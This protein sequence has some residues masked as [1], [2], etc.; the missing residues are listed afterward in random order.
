MHFL[1]Q[2]LCPHLSPRRWAPQRQ[3]HYWPEKAARGHLLVVRNDGMF[4]PDPPSR[5]EG[6]KEEA[7]HDG[8]LHPTIQKVVLT[9][10]DEKAD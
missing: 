9:Q 5:G 7:W 8:S 1:P 4:L 10:R 3:G 2:Q 6:R